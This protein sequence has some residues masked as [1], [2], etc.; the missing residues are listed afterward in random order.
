MKAAL[1][2]LIASMSKSVVYQSPP[3]DSVSV[4]P[5]QAPAQPPARES[6]NGERFGGLIMRINLLACSIG[7]SPGFTLKLSR[8]FRSEIAPL[9]P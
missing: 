4:R 9:G 5:A 6:C 3:F 1:L 2:S 7:R 8:S